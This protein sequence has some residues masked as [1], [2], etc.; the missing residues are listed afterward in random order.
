MNQRFCP[1]CKVRLGSNDHYFCHVCGA[2]LPEELV[3]PGE[4]NVRVMDVPE[5]KHVFPNYKEKIQAVTKD[6]VHILNVK[7]IVMV[8]ILGGLVGIPVYLWLNNFTSYVSTPIVDET[9]TPKLEVKAP[10]V[11]L[12]EEYQEHIFGSNTITDYVPY[13]V[14]LYIEGHDF[15]KMSKIFEEYDPGYT[16]LFEKLVPVVDPHFGAFLT[17]V[18][19]EYVWTLILFPYEDLLDQNFDYGDISWINTQRIDESLIVSTKVTFDL[20][21]DAKMKITKNLAI[22]PVYDKFIKESPK[23]G[24]LQII[25]FTQGGRLALQ[26]LLSQDIPQEMREVV[27]KYL[28]TKSDN[29]VFK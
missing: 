19:E 1:N 6:V 17:K 15:P 27:T 28:E 18:E 29:V 13:D 24:S 3:I 25:A 11:E 20:V 26:Q 4:N 14:D 9:V 23:S 2:E 21:R 7:E 22:N 16:P 5:R 8:L 12:N 10:V